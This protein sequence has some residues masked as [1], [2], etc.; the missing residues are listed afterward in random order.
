MRWRLF[1]IVV[2]AAAAVSVSANAVPVNLVTNGSFE[3]PVIPA[4][5]GGLDEPSGWLFT[6]A[7]NGSLAGVISGPPH[8]GTNTYTFEASGGLND[9]ISQTIGTVVGHQYQIR[10]WVH[11]DGHAGT[12]FIGS[13]GGQQ[14]VELIDPPIVSDPANRGYELFSM[15]AT[16]TSNASDLMFAGR[17]RPGELFL[18]DVGVF[19]MTPTDLVESGTIAL[20]LTGLVGF[21]VARRRY[22]F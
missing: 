12:D 5:N 13:F 20:L 19:D 10:F 17:D 6:P 15:I 11:P 21:G 1:A 16:A 2:A 7:A 14:L 4:S 18:D 3:G 9:T 22:S 8:S